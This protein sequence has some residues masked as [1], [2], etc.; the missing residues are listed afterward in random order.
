MLYGDMWTV[1]VVLEDTKYIRTIR[2]NK[3]ITIWSEARISKVSDQMT[4][5]NLSNRYTY[6]P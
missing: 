4:H 6:Y 1:D 5:P 2:R 3:L